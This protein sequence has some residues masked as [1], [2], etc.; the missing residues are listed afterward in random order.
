MKDATGDWKRVPLGTLAEF[1]NGINYSKDNFGKGV[2]VINVKDFQDLSLAPFKDLDEINPEGVVKEESFLHEGDIIFV[3]SNGNR[4]LIGR[5][6]FVN[7]PPEKVTHSAFTIEALKLGLL[8]KNLFI[9]SL[10]P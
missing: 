9:F 3:R 6:L 2:K 1:R 8:F 7:N 4:Q 5:S 10:L